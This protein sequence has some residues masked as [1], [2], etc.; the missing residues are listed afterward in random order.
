MIKLALCADATCVDKG[1]VQKVIEHL[2]QDLARSFIVKT[3]FIWRRPRWARSETLIGIVYGKKEYSLCSST[4]L[5][6]RFKLL[7]S[8]LFQRIRYSRRYT[9]DSSVTECVKIFGVPEQC[10]CNG[11]V[12]GLK[13]WMSYISIV[14]HMQTHAIL[15]LR[16]YY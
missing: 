4:C 12:G 2:G 6:Q 16:F 11:S 3:C 8:M 10:Y 14:R 9:I 7:Q 5:R 1:F 15:H 13:P